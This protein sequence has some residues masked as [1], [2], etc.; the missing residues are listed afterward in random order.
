[1]PE[2]KMTKELDKELGEELDKEPDK[3]LD[4]E[5]DKELDKEPDKELDKEPD[6]VLGKV[7]RNKHPG[8]V[9][10]GQRLQSVLRER[11]ESAKQNNKYY[12]G[13]GLLIG[14]FITMYYATSREKPTPTTPGPVRKQAIIFDS[15]I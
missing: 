11:R 13:V 8:R 15:D 9:A 2:K 1:M 6:K 12:V 14:L 4:K 5:P 10:A 3:E 7:P